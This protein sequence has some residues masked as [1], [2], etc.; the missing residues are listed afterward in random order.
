MK[1]DKETTRLYHKLRREGEMKLNQD[2]INLSLIY[3]Y[4]L[5]LENEISRFKIL[6]DFKTL[7]YFDTSFLNSKFQINQEN[8]KLFLELG[9]KRYRQ[10]KTRIKK[11]K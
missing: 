10:L 8:F 2:L 6:E 1:I 9:E 4:L 5:E 11:I 3:K 7:S